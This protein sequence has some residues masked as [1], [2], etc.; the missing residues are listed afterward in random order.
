MFKNR[1]DAA[2]K[3]LARLKNVAPDTII[4]AIPRGSL[5]IGAILSEKLNLP[6]DIVVTKKIPA[7]GNPEFAVGA[8]APDEEALINKEIIGRHGIDEDYIESIKRELMNQIRKRYRTYKGGAPRASNGSNLPNFT[9]KKIILIDDGIATGFTVKAAIAYLRRVKVKEIT[10]AVPVCAPD[11]AAEL[12]TL[13]DTFIC[14]ESPADFAAVGQYYQ[15][16]PQV[17]DAEAIDY[18]KNSTLKN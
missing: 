16:F 1:Q 13:V 12:K 11:A 8:L 14:L 6:L 18:L 17:T 10:V 2:Q 9:G 4:V 3:L 7:P 15:E 5:E